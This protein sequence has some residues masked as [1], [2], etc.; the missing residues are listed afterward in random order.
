MT[1]PS[2]PSERAEETDVLE[3]GFP[4][5]DLGELRC[6]PAESPPPV[7]REDPVLHQLRSQQPTDLA[8]E[9][10]EKEPFSGLKASQQH[11]ERNRNVGDHT[12]AQR[13]RGGEERISTHE[14]PGAVRAS[15]RTELHIPFSKKARAE[16]R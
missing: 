7:Y 2:P 5:N 6:A 10:P 9:P 14:S 13:G 15:R 4:Q 11:D 8:E 1:S 12:L 16:D 3:G